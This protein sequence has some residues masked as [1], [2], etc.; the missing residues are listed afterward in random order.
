MSR[1]GVFVSKRGQFFILA[2]VILS[3]FLF[4]LAFTVNEV[5]ANEEN[6]GFHDYAEGIEREVDNVLDYQVYSNIEELDGFIAMLEVDF[7]DRGEEGNFVFVYGNSD[8]GMRIK[9]V[10][11]DSIEVG[12]NEDEGGGVN[13][14]IVLNGAENSDESK[15]R[16]GGVG[17]GVGSV[18]TENRETV[19][20]VPEDGNIDIYFN[21]QVY[22]FPVSKVN[23][24]IFIIQKDVKDETYVEVR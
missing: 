17:I 7:R 20:T 23:Q 13:S 14:V 10:G 22:K 4:S 9:N 6:F 11:F 8:D 21:G 2:A 19:I 12:E 18:N 24:V 1:K 16:V 3:V 5:V 15:I